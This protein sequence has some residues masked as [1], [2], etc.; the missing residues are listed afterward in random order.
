MTHPAA[1]P[2]ELTSEQI[3]LSQLL[4]AVGACDSGGVAKH[5]IQ[6][7]EVAVNGTKEFRRGRKLAAGDVVVYKGKAYEV[8]A[9]PTG[10]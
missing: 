6:A 8:R 4:K 1:I 7:G 5:V 3:E 2:F 10:E 9:A